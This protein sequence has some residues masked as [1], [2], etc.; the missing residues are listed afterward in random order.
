MINHV[1]RELV[2]IDFGLSDFYHV[3]QPYNV[4]VA[5]RFY[6]PPEILIGYGMYDYSFDLWSFGCWFAGL[7]K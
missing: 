2:L 5:S 7:V 1:K 3:G 6:K 4:R